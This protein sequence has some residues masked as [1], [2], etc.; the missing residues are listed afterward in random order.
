MLGFGLFQDI[1]IILEKYYY[2]KEFFLKKTISGLYQLNKFF[3]KNVNCRF[4]RLFLLS[5]KQFNYC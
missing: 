4:F 2:G 1:R 5:F 3:Y